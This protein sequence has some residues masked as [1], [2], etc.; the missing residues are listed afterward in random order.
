MAWGRI[1]SEHAGAKRGKGYWGRKTAAKV[2]SRRARRREARTAVIEG[3]EQG[4][5]G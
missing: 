5:S 4:R 1:K 3:L 2:A